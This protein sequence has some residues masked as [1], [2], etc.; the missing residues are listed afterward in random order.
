[1]QE[2]NKLDTLR[3]A[4]RKSRDKKRAKKQKENNKSNDCDRDGRQ[5]IFFGRNEKKR[6][7]L[8]REKLV[9]FSSM[10]FAYTC[11]QVERGVL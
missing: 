3:K 11:S 1:M 8:G 6:K 9:S 5:N 2:L 7:R 10:I 4:D